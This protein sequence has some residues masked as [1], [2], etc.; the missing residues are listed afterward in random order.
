MVLGFVTGIVLTR[1]LGAQGRGLVVAVLVYP[2]LFVSFAQ[3]G[4]RQSATYHL[5]KRVFSDESVV[6]VMVTLTLLMSVIGVAAVTPLVVG[7]GGHD[8]TWA[9]AALAVATVPVSLATTNASGILLG[10]RQVGQFVGIACLTAVL[11]LVLMV[12]LL[13][14]LKRGVT[15]ALAATFVADVLVAAYAVVRVAR[16]AGLRPRG[17]LRV[18]RALVLRGVAYAFALFVLTL[19]YSVD[20]ALMKHFSTTEQIGVYAVAVAVSTIVWSLPQSITSALFSYSSNAPDAEA[21]SAKVARLFRVTF[22]TSIVVFVV[23]GAVS[24]FLIPV[25]YGPA[26]KASVAPFLIILP[27]SFCLLALKTLNVDLAGQGRPYVSL[28]AT[29]PAL[30]VNVVLNIILLPAHGAVGAAIASLASYGLAGVVFVLVY[31][32]ASGVGLRRLWRFRLSDFSFVPQLLA[33]LQRRAVD[34]P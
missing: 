8:Y 34:T 31:A 10:K 13:L 25:F 3:L 16:V 12:L 9:M 1:A 2:S 29:V 17:D 7:S 22:L 24:P 20:I 19:N 33:G 32:R 4:L 21:F 5:G 27:G 30:A 11:E 15:G 23:L 26:F 28:I 14:V 18:G 6:G